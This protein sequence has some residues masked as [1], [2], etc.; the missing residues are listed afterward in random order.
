M[1]IWNDREGFEC[2]IGYIFTHIFTQIFSDKQKPTVFSKYTPLHIVFK[3]ISLG[4]IE[5]LILW[6]MYLNYLMTKVNFISR[7]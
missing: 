6:Q 2:I 7:G 4:L 3:K 1:I 5:C